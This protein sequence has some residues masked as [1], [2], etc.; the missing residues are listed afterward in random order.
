MATIVT[1]SGKG[2]SLTN[3]EVD[4]NFTNL[5]TAKLELGGGTLTGNLNFGDNVKAMFGAGSDLQIYHDGGNS[6]ILE[7][8]TGFLAI[9]TSGTD[10]RL[11][12]QSFNEFMA[13][14]EQDGP[15][16]LYYNNAPKLATTTT[17]IDVTGNV[18]LPDNGKL[19]L[20]TGNDLQLHHDGNNSFVDQVGTGAL[21]LRAD[22]LNITSY[23][24]TE[25]Y[26][27]MAVN[28]SVTLYNN[29]IAKLSTTAT[30][31]DVTGTVVADGLTSSG[32]I[33]ANGDIT[34]AGQLSVTSTGSNVWVKG[35]EAGFVSSTT[36]EYMLRATTNGSVKLYDNNAI[37]LETTTTGIDVTG[38]VVADGLTVDGGSSSPTHL[39]TGAR[40]G[41]L[42]S[43]DNEST[44]TSYGLLTNTASVS[45]NS[46]PLWVT[47][48]DA[49][50]LTVGGNGDIS[51]YEDT[52]TTA[53]FFWDASAESLGIGTSSPSGALE[54]VGGASLGSGFTQSRSGHPTFGITNGGTDS[55]YFS[56]APNGGSHQTFMQVRD[57]DTD[58]SSVAFSTSGAERMTIDSSG[59]V[60]VNSS[61][62]IYGST[63]RGVLEL[64][65]TGTAGSL[66]G[67]KVGGTH[68]GYIFAA[69]DQMQ[70]YNHLAT[71]LKFFTDATERM[72]IDSS[73]NVLVGTDNNSA[74]AGNT[75]T[76]IS[77]RGGTDNR[78][79][80]S[81]N[82][83]YVMHLNRKGNDGNILEFAKD[84]SNVGSIGVENGDLNINGDT[85]I[86]FQDTSIM[87]RRAGSDVDATVDIGLSSHRWKDLY[88]SGGVY[89]GGTGAANKLDDYEEVN[90]TATLQ[91]STATPSTLVTV[92]GFAT[93]IGRVVQ[94]SI[95]FEGINTTGYGGL[96]S[97]TGLPFANNG[98][99][100]IGNIVGYV[101]L[102][103]AGTQSFS[104]LGVASTI[105][106]ALNI[107]S[108]SAWANSTHN[109]GTGRYF[110]LTGTY[111]TTA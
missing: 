50:R 45:A 86:R 94:Y 27:G 38:T 42:V 88:L 109:A 79:F 99:R 107:S 97:V 96:V 30:G 52:G 51:F 81:V 6:R 83:D 67:L 12:G 7:N 92:T 39:F 77:L 25:N 5:N 4:A 15:V 22:T 72:R 13:K 74:G 33:V 71:P 59:N 93:K 84:G 36:G 91:G 69:S 31:I 55:V 2:S 63:N 43:I 34:K 76:G 10:I 48:N 102:T 47:S 46:Y 17:G 104:V 111:M 62:P 57:D 68:A 16:T 19:L 60:L 56:L 26:L 87:P 53:K 24:G 64:N 58:V 95:G 106:E 101:G 61:S 65:G 80:F 85:G 8:G 73:G 23:T 14:F 21:Y 98:G 29:N 9:G 66:L 37:K 90:F 110:W 49:N 41:T 75:A 105:L 32:A 78:S 1:R 100:A 3:N 108:A 44:S 82:Q 11:T 70:V 89:L 35:V 28:G 40:A 18:D 103:F 54:V 20:G